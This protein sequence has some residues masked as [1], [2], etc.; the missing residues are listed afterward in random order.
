MFVVLL[1]F[2]ANRSRAGEWMDAHNAWLQRGFDDGVFVASGSLQG[3]QGGA[4]LA[5]SLDAT[6]LQQ[7][8]SEDPFVAHDVVSVEMIDVALSKVDPRLEF[9]SGNLA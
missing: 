8:L 1:K 5:R 3:Q 9:L 4:I 7:R 6:S 2:S